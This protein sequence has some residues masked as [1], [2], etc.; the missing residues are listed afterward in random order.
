MLS[1]TCSICGKEARIVSRSLD[2]AFC[3]AS[4]YSKAKYAAMKR[5]T[6]AEEIPK[7]CL[8]CDKICP[9]PKRGKTGDYCSAHCRRLSTLTAQATCERCGIAYT[10]WAVGSRWCSSCRN[11]EAAK[12]A[13]QKAGERKRNCRHCSAEFTPLIPV[14][15]FC[16]PSCNN[17]HW[18]QRKQSSRR[19]AFVEDVSLGYL[20][21][22]DN[23][24]CQICR[25]S[26]D[27][28]LAHPDPLSASIDHIQPLSKGGEH[29]KQNCQLAHLGCNSAKGT[30]TG[31]QQLLVG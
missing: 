27:M 24:I 22:R 8:R 10:T 9:K 3:S 28:S 21:E 20:V 1:L 4:C 30:K 25:E 2:S 19:A 6:G 11:S 5:L 29:S 16:S 31:Y 17:R 12:A 14:Q 26:V 18:A 15:R 23:G 7:N 13:N